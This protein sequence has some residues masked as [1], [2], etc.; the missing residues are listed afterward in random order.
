VVDIADDQENL[1][2]NRKIGF[3]RKYQVKT[4]NATNFMCIATMY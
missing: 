2:E 1:L 3:L 4:G